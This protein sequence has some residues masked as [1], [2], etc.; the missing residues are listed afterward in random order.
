MN[1]FRNLIFILLLPLTIILEGQEPQFRLRDLD[2]KWQEYENIKG[3][4]LTVIDFWA[5]WC[6]P[7]V[8]SIPLLNE[9][10]EEFETQGVSFIGISIDGPRNQS[11]VKPFIQ[12]MGV[13]YPIIR[14]VDSELMAELGVS[15]V[16]TLLIYDSKGELVYFH[17]GFK[18]GDEQTIRDHISE[19]L[20]N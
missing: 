17:E 10:A 6:Q 20:S 8:R 11:K 13:T 9:I 1:K 2:N 3:S 19:Q 5:T 4:Q 15:A 14:D 7:C 16:P 18:P 12:S